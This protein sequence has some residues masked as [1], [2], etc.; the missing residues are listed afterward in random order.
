M[1]CDCSSTRRSLLIL[2]R[3]LSE[4]YPELLTLGHSLGWTTHPEFG[5]LR[6]E[7]VDGAGAVV[8]AATLPHGGRLVRL[9]VA[10]RLPSGVY[11]IRV[12][13]RAGKAVAKVEVVH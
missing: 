3:N 11:L 10:G 7:V 9:P 2:A 12:T 8:A 1:A 4:N 6:V 13:E 5:A